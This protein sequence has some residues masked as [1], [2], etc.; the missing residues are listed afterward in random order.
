MLQISYLWAT[1]IVEGS[2]TYAEVP[3]KLKAEVAQILTEQGHEDLI[4]E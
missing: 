3:S 1:K 4:V 2:R